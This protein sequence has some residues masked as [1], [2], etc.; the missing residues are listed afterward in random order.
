MSVKNFF[1][2]I[3]LLVENDVQLLDGFRNSYSSVFVTL[4]LG[5][6]ANGICKIYSHL[7][8]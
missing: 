6:Q 5:C 3:A 2:F 8:I 4:D 1:F 7:T